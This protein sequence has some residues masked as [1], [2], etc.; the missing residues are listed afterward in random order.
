MDRY[1][2]QLNENH[3]NELDFR[4][5][6]AAYWKTMWDNA[7]GEKDAKIF[8]QKYIDAVNSIRDEIAKAAK[9]LQSQFTNSINAIFDQ[10]DKKLTNG[11][12]LDYVE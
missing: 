4:R 3:K 7:D 5:Q 12:G 9:D 8:K 2:N 6:E 10:L 11:K 1:Y